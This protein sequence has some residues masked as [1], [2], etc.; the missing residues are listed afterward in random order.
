MARQVG[1]WVG[2]W[3]GWLAGGVLRC[4]GWLPSTQLVSCYTTRD[5]LFVLGLPFRHVSHFFGWGGCLSPRGKSEH[6]RGVF[7]LF[8][9]G[10]FFRGFILEKIAVW[11]A[12]RPAVSSL[13]RF[14]LAFRFV[15][16][17][18]AL[19]VVI[20]TKRRCFSKMAEQCVCVCVCVCV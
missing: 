9:S 12:G 5:L 19:A 15:A 4:L 20:N 17:P 6:F 18:I 1:G 2:G 13:T 10:G 16:I 11:V 7:F 3:V 14:A 8:Y